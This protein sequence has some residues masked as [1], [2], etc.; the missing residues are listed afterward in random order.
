MYKNVSGQKWVVFA[1]NSTTNA[2]VT[3]DAANITAKISIDGAAGAGTNDTNPTELE[4]GKYVFD[5]TQAETNG[6]LLSI[7]PESSTSNVVVRGEPPSVY[8]REQTPDV[9]VSQISGDSVAALIT[10]RLCLIT[11]ATTHRIAQLV[12][13]LRLR[14][15]P[16]RQATALRA[17]ALLLA[18]LSL[19]ISLLLTRWLTVYKRIWATAQTD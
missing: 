16:R 1:F 11:R 5:L 10:W 19:R 12:R 15:T 14:A 17:W 8:T 4:D 18:L 3:G 2:P 7:L 6:D 9:N 13:C